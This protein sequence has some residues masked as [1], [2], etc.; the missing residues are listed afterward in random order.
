MRTVIQRVLSASVSIDGRIVSE[1]GAGVAVL[2]GLH[3]DDTPGDSDYIISKI[4][5]L[6]IF[7]DPGGVMNLSLEETCGEILIVSQFTLYGD[8]RKGRRPSYS[9]AMPPER[10]EEFYNCFLETLKKKYPRVSSGVFGADMKV[11]LVNNGPV[12]ILLESSKTF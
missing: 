12:T 9:E 5:G 1:I 8:A 10:A 4:I 2:L 3:R 11:S 6:R 7:D